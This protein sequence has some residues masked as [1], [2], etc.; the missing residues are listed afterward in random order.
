MY[1]FDKA[2]VNIYKIQLCL[3]WRFTMKIKWYG[4]AC[5][6]IISGNY[7]VVIDP[8]SPNSVPG[9]SPL[10]L[11]ADKVLCTHDHHDHNAKDAVE[12][13]K[14]SAS[15]FKYATVKTFHDEV[16]GEKRG[17]NSIYILEAEG[18]RVAHFGDLGCIPTDEQL[19]TIGNLDAAMIPVG[20]YYTI[21]A[22]TAKLILS[23]LDVKVIIPMHY[24]NGDVG[25]GVLDTLDTFESLITDRPA[26]DYGDEIEIA[27][28][29]EKQLAVLNI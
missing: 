15:P 11:K 18:L 23:K 6:K 21:D 22:K 19:N 29:T 3:L 12:L 1:N 25:Y 7:S 4:H 8:Y 5:F 2:N 28:D 14:N 17:K 26:F 16:G 9:L 13:I 10:R 24:R 27:V 20:G